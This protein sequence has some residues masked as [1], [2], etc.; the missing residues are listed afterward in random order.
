MHKDNNKWAKTS[1][2]DGG[3]IRPSHGYLWHLENQ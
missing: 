3:G 2:N 1:D